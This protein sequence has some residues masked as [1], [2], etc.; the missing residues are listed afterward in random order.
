MAR[1][2][3]LPEIIQA[4]R[5]RLAQQRPYLASLLYRLTPVAQ[6]GIG[7]MAV[8]KYARLYF[9]PECTWTMEQY[10]TV[11][12]HEVCHLL[13][14]HAGRGESLGIEIDQQGNWNIAADAEIN[15]DIIAE[16]LTTWPFEAVTP[17]AIGQADGLFAEEYYANR[18]K[19]GKNQ[20]D[21][22]K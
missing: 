12:Y 14:D 10:A 20:G 4:A 21:K 13:R 15:D 11:M 9:D 5:V 16:G 22:G 6:P 19:S 2:V 17:K 3:D 1:H 18:P 7:T 8:D